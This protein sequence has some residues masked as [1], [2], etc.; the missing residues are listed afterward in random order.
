MISAEVLGHCS[1]VMHLLRA[2]KA[3]LEFHIEAMNGSSC[4]IPLWLPCSTDGFCSSDES[5]LQTSLLLPELLTLAASRPY[6][7]LGGA[8][9]SIFLK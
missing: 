7:L 4:S 3:T 6:A 5:V 2:F 8:A 9:G 1:P